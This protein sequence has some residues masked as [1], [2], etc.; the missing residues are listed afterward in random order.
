MAQNI[1]EEL[2]CL[3]GKLQHQ[4]VEQVC[5]EIWVVTGTEAQSWLFTGLSPF[6]SFCPR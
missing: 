1:R 5:A 3:W 4:G 2:S 6:S